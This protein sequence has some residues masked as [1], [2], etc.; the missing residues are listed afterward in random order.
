MDAQ[1]KPYTTINQQ[2]D[3]LKS[4]GMLIDPA[5]AQ[6]WLSYVG[7]YR[8]SG[9]WY[10]CRTENPA[11]TGQR[12][13]IRDDTFQPNT[14]FSDIVKLYEFDRKLR[15]LVHDGI[16]RVEIA[17]RTALAETLGAMGPL[18]FYQRDTF[19]INPR[20]EFDHYQLISTVTGRISRSLN[21]R[22]RTSVHHN[23][24]KYGVL[25][26]P[27]VLADVLDFSD[28]SKTYSM[29]KTTEQEKIADLL[30][31]DVS[32]IRRTSNQN[33][34]YRDAHPLAS[35]LRQLTV[36]RNKAAH[37]A[38]IWNCSLP[39]VGTPILRQ[40]PQL[41]SL[42]LPQSEKLY[43]ALTC[44]AYTLEAVSPGSS[45]SKNVANLVQDNLADIPFLTESQMGFPN[46][47][48]QDPLW[49]LHTP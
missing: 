32:S 22:E 7:Y 10:I 19:R 31:F 3:L 12:T 41:S 25:L 30:G 35:V 42:P 18:A 11:S 9:Y 14:D 44:I 26:A 28:M 47:W 48:E 4:R 2:I 16:E 5:E 36:L 45:W 17:G 43:G 34:A 1:I 13:P 40:I 21:S 46:R 37:H 6:Q 8:L 15:T 29:L 39:P 33:S 27:W 23:V 24:E 49:K 20:K 38:R